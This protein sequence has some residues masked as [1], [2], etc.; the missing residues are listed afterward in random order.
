MFY[1]LGFVFFAAM[2]VSSCRTNS[3]PLCWKLGVLVTGLGK[4]CQKYFLGGREAREGEDGYIYIH[5]CTYIY[6]HTKL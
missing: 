2:H 1:V 5:I 3:C 6:T 4:S